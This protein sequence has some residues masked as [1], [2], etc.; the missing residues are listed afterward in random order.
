MDKHK[1][2]ITNGYLINDFI[3]MKKKITKTFDNDDQFSFF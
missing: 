1:I 2:M 3:K